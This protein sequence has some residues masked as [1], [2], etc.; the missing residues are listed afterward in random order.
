MKFSEIPKFTKT[1]HY[2][3]NVSWDGLKEQ[4]RH[5]S[6]DGISPVELNSDFQRGHVWSKEQQITFVEYKLANGP[7]A[8]IIHFNC[9]GWMTSFKG[10]FVCVDGLQRITAVLAFLNNEI[11]VY[12][13]YLYEFED[14]HLLRRI[15]FIFNVNDLNT[16]REV[17]KWYLEINYQGTPHTKEELIRVKNLL[18]KCPK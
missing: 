4:I 11:K 17:L 3:I 15:D 16:K 14:T 12:G 5:W 13:H 8:D 2:N 1:S 18:T 6:E 10:P 9:V 7:G